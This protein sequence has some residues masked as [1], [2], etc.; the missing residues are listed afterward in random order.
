MSYQPSTLSF[1]PTQLVHLSS[2]DNLA[3]RP[4]ILKLALLREFIPYI[5]KLGSPAFLRKLA[6]WTPLKSIQDAVK[7]IDIMDVTS[8]DIY[9][10]KKEA[11]AQGDVE[12]IKQ[13]GQGKDI[14]SIL[15][16]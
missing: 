13:V 11:L 2:T 12:A 1:C 16:E 8:R 7:I 6:E 15:C 9:K 3:L 14:M 10:K 5:V 4:T